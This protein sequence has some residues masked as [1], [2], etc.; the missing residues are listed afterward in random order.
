M[1]RLIY[2]KDQIA[3]RTCAYAVYQNSCTM[4]CDYIG[5]E[6]HSRTIKDGKR[7]LPKGYCDKY[8]EKK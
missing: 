4:C 2:V 6:E 8:K 1:S 7:R 5:I 3:C